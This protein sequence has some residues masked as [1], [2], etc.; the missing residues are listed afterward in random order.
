MPRRCLFTLVLLICGSGCPKKGVSRTPGQGSSVKPQKVAPVPKHSPK[1][2]EKG[3]VVG[4]TAAHNAIRRQHRLPDLVWSN[5]LAAYAE[6]WGTHLQQH[7]CGLAHRPSAGRFRQLYGENLFAIAGGQANPREVVQA[8]AS[9]ARYYH[10][11]SNRCRG[12]C[13]HYTQIVWRNSR[14]L[15]CAVKSCGASE[16]WVCNYD[17][18]GNFI[19]QRPY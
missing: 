2:Q 10:Y 18:P 6:Q 11:P 7:R 1:A 3:R 4:I 13:G 14:R 16:V 9:E 8:W 15:G 19:H 12:I 5:E 17:P